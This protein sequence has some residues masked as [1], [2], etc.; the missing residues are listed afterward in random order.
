MQKKI[1]RKYFQFTFS[2]QNTFRPNSLAHDPAL[3]ILFS[4]YKVKT[5]DIEMDSELHGF[6]GYFECTLYKDIMI[7]INPTT[8]SPGLFTF[9]ISCLFTIFVFSSNQIV[10]FTLFFPGMFSWF[11]IFFPLKA[12][13]KLKEGDKLELHFWRL[14][15]SKEVWYVNY[16][17]SCLFTFKNFVKS[18]SQKKFHEIDFTKKL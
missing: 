12:P 17:F 8:H 1:C 6:G 16:F 4:R 5:F 18:F 2:L 10:L 7:S 14:N 11:P 3:K 13:M 15:N 9:N